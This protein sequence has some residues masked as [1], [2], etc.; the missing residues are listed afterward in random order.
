MKFR[1]LMTIPVFAVLVAVTG[2]GTS[3]SGNSNTSAQT[4]VPKD[5]QVVHVTAQDYSWTLDKS[6]F[7]D[8]QPIVFDL[9]CT[10]GSH[11]FAI[12]GTNINVPIASGQ[13]KTVVWT[14][15]KAGTY[16]IVCSKFC[17]P[18]HEQMVQKFKVV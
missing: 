15:K 10:S 6:T 14:P 18:G 5:A 13:T 8:N 1:S 12:S 11:G 16:T 4:S 7:K 3:D 2:C 17:G 9:S